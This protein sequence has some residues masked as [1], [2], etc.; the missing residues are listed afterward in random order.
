MADKED[1][2][3]GF[4]KEQITMWNRWKQI[5]NM[6]ASELK[7][8]RGSDDADEVGLDTDQAKRA[9]VS[10]QSGHEMSKKIERVIAKAAGHK[11]FLPPKVW[12]SDDW[13]VVGSTINY[14]SRARANKGDLTDDEGNPTPKK[15]ALMLWGRKEKEGSSFPDKD[16]VKDMVNK[17]L[18]ETKSMKFGQYLRTLI[19][20]V[21]SKE[22]GKM[23]KKQIHDLLTGN[24][25][26]GLDM[27]SDDEVTLAT[28]EFSAVLSD[29][30][31]GKIKSESINVLMPEVSSHEL[32][33]I[34]QFM[35]PA[36]S[37]RIFETIKN[38]ENSKQVFILD[39]YPES[40]LEELSRILDKHKNLPS[41]VNYLTAVN[42]YINGAED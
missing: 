29:I 32:Q 4:S 12:S 34:V 6:D 38:S 9:G 17:K 36:D 23:T 41:V 14:I 5:V 25:F 35:S 20:D 11:G 10:V 30:A 40:F 42:E 2:K 28:A 15:L 13:E 3:G 26:L 19:E 33:F 27:D 7:R 8:F 24:E 16:D 18:Q 22:I 1:K 39:H 37:T 31:N 21:E